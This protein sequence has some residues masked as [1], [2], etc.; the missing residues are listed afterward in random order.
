MLHPNHRSSC[1]SSFGWQVLECETWNIM[2]FLFARAD[3]ESSEVQ[4]FDGNHLKC[5]HN[6]K[7]YMV[8]VSKQIKLRRQ[9]T[10][11]AKQCNIINGSQT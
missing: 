8:I 1:L 5:D 2:A 6:Q 9:A 7:S 4:V 3:N 10:K 11:R